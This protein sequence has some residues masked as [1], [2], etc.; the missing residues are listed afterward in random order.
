ML[1][2]S[3]VAYKKWNLLYF[4][5]K[6]HTV[7]YSRL[8]TTYPIYTLRDLDF[9]NILNYDYHSAYEPTV[10]HH[11]ALMPP[12][13]TSEYAWNAQLNVVGIYCTV[14]YWLSML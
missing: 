2:I 9:F 14:H 4:P 10:N 1:K 8:T 7:Q 5:Q 12:P 3:T 13:G 6:E 11:A